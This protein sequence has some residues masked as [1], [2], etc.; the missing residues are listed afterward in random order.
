MA[1]ITWRAQDFREG[2]E[3]EFA[4]PRKGT[5]K[6][7]G[8]ESIHIQTNMGERFTIAENAGVDIKL[9]SRPFTP[10]PEGS[11]VRFGGKSAA[12]ACLALSL[13]DR[14]YQYLQFLTKPTPFPARVWPWFGVE[15]D[16]VEIIKE[17][18]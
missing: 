8:V 18:A 5:V 4:L 7:V 13:G 3:V 15:H 16:I 11:V 12:G 6:G 10:P 1:D 9:I 17:S 2:D 14:G